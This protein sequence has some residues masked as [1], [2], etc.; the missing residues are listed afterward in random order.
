LVIQEIGTT[1][2]VTVQNWFTN[3]WS[4]LLWI[5]TGDG[6]T[7]DPGAV[8]QLIANMGSYAAANPGFTPAASGTIIASSALASLWSVTITGT[9][10][11]DEMTA[12]AIAGAQIN[13]VASDDNDT[14][15]AG[16]NANI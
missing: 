8:A 14:I 2:Q 13:F 4:Q 15:N 6:G 16:A 3:P 10:S 5:D 11:S 1:S 9:S 12:P 7:L